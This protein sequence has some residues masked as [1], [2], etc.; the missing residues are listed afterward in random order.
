[1]FQI[2]KSYRLVLQAAVSFNSINATESFKNYITSD[3]NSANQQKNI[4][5]INT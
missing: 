2:T 5:S 1:M 4:I 3:I